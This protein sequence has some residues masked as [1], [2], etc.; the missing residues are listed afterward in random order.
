MSIPVGYDIGLE[1]HPE[2]DQFLRIED[3][4]AKV[5]M[6]L[7]YAAGKTTDGMMEIVKT[8]KKRDCTSG[9]ASLQ[10]QKANLF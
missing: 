7:F 6:G 1:Q 3:G 10:Q 9:T 5:M 8:I 2:M 4:Q